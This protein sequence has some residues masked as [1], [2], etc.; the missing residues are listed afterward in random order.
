[1]LVTL[2]DKKELTQV[3]ALDYVVYR[4]QLETVQLAEGLKTVGILELL[5][6]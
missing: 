4:S 3:I 2:Q 6:N 5:R 1:M